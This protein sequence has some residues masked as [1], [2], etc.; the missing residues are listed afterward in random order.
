MV[1]QRKKSNK[2]RRNGKGFKA[3]GAKARKINAST[4]FETC[5][6]QLS[7]F[8]G[9][10]ALIKF[11]DLVRFKEIFDCTYLAPRREPKLGHHLMVV[12][13]LMLLFIGFNR[14]WHF[15]YIR[16][17]AML[18]GFF[19][20]T[21]L[22]VAS[23]FWRYVDS[24]GINQANAFLTIMST[25]R[26]RVWQLCEIEYYR[27]RIS[28]DTTVETIFGNQQGG[29]KGHNTK[30]R[31]KKALRPILC[32]ID[33]TREYLMGKLRKGQTVSGKEAADFI[34]KIKDH[35]PGCVHQVLL[36]AD[37]EF[38]SWQSVAACIE[39]GFDFIIAN[40]GCEP[41]FDPNSWYRPWKRK[42]IEYNSCQYQP[43]GWGVACRFVVMR[44]PKQLAKKPGQAIQCVLFEDER[45]QYR[46]FCT[47]PGG[48]AH[49]I[50]SEYDKRADVEN[51]VGEARREGLD[52]IPSAKFKTNYAYFQIVMLAY[53]IWRY[54]KMIA[55][56][57]IGDDQCD[58]ADDVAKGLQGIMNNTIR[59]ARLKLLFIAA[60][61]VKESNVDKVKYSI[62]DARTPAMLHFLKFL[63]KARVKL[64]PWEED[65]SWPQRFSLQTV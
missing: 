44:I 13:I 12:G 35:L 48:K 41:V 54:L 1:K 36:R 7:P 27:I 30:H 33:E 60:K 6:E 38:L 50:I 42:N 21:K 29:R 4:E 11:L 2:K 37:G 8:G 34:K 64:R 3:N 43:G 5:T 49:K 47:N 10:L 65:S 14:L 62:H 45:Y 46:V 19:R 17:D 39:A 61:V 25:L 57:G 51:L 55:Q 52:A 32:F 58:Q 53:N 40:K 24:L 63:D 15:T 31:G 18:C 56:L 22:P 28:I 20:L 16:L 26:E 23:T 59:I 9:L